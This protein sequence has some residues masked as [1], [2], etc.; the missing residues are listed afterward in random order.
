MTPTNT[1]SGAGSKPERSQRRIGR[2]AC[3]HRPHRAGASSGRP[4]GD[5]PAGRRRPPQS[6]RGAGCAP[7]RRWRHDPGAA[8][9]GQ[10]GRRRHARGALPDDPS[11]PWRVARR[12]RHAGR[13]RVHDRRGLRPGPDPRRRP[14]P[15]PADARRARPAP[16]RRRPARGA[17]EDPRRARA[18]L[19]EPVRRHHRHVVRGVG[20]QR[21]RRAGHRRLQ[22][23]GRHRSPHALHGRDR[24]LGAV[25][26]Q[27]RRPAPPTSSRSWARTGSGGRRPTRWRST[28]RYRPRRARSS[29]RRP[30]SG[31]TTTG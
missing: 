27:H 11:A 8:P 5:R 12:H 4:L 21:R 1:P 13:A 2:D 16:D 3:R 10:G 6:P 30:T 18:H 31:R 14:V 28:P 26:P 7:L 17:V 20:A 9:D 29:T 22:R 19:P 23:L 15:V 24:R 25:H